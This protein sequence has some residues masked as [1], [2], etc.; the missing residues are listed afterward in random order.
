MYIVGVVILEGVVCFQAGSARIPAESRPC[1]ACRLQRTRTSCRP[2]GLQLLL[3]SNIL[4]FVVFANTGEA[5]YLFRASPGGDGVKPAGLWGGQINHS[6]NGQADNLFQR[7]YDEVALP[8]AFKDENGLIIRRTSFDPVSWTVL[9]EVEDITNARTIVAEAAI[10]PIYV[11]FSDDGSPIPLQ[12]VIPEVRLVDINHPFLMEC[13]WK[14]GWAA[15]TLYGGKVYFVLSALFGQSSSSLRRE[16]QVRVLYQ[17]YKQI[18]QNISQKAG[19][20]VDDFD[21][22]QYSHHVATAHAHGYAI[23]DEITTWLSSSLQLVQSSLDST[24]YFYLQLMKKEGSKVTMNLV[25]VKQNDTSGKMVYSEQVPSEYGGNTRIRGFGELDYND[26]ML[27]WTAAETLI[28]AP[29]EGSELSIKS[30]IVGPG[31]AQNKG[32]CK[33]K[34]S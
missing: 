25:Q 24:W 23:G 20:G 2:N 17:G 21:V 5:G 12:T 11:S 34:Y 26:G 4:L 27:C 22:L 13:G 19:P 10:C 8:S 30:V 28:C 33:S 29:V 15:F 14:C 7:G 1:H 18:L 3:L 32:I 9:V 6:D 31:D 16:I